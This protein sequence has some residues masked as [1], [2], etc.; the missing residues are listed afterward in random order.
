MGL[1]EQSEA[2]LSEP[3]H[4]SCE[5]QVVLTLLCRAEGNVEVSRKLGVGSLAAA[6]G[7]VRWDRRGR[8]H[9]LISN[10]RGSDGGP[11][12]ERMV[13]VEREVMCLL[14]HD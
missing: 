4:I 1:I 7:D 8:A 2:R 11:A 6:F 13:R 14:P 12:L 9:E 5:Q 10:C 3:P